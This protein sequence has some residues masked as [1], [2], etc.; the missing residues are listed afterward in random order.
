MKWQGKR[1]EQR[2]CELFFIAIDCWT[3]LS[4]PIDLL[5]LTGFTMAM[6]RFS[7]PVFYFPCSSM[8]LM[9]RGLPETSTYTRNSQELR[10]K[11]NVPLNNQDRHPSSS[12]MLPK[13]QNSHW[14]TL[15]RDPSKHSCVTFLTKHIRGSKLVEKL[16]KKVAK[17]W[18][19]RSHE[20]QPL[21]KTNCKRKKDQQHNVKPAKK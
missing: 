7:E 20:T 12:K 17:G 6:L 18:D 10:S 15:S 19:T 16:G 13:K 9:H 1:R 3:L 5:V 21:I 11:Q 2:H 4:V 14:G 8:S